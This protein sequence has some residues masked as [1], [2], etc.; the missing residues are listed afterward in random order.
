MSIIQ[1]PRRPRINLL[2]LLAAAFAVGTVWSGMRIVHEDRRQIIRMTVRDKAIEIATL[3]SERLHHLGRSDSATVRKAFEDLLA[4]DYVSDSTR[5]LHM[6]ARSISVSDRGVRV[7]GPPLDSTRILESAPLHGD[8]SHIVVTAMV[9]G[10]QLPSEMIFPFS[11]ERLITNG[12]FILGTMLTL[13]AAIVV[14]RRELRLA[15]ARS[16]FV[17]GVSHDLRMPLAQ[18]LLASETLAM[19]R[20]R[21][22]ADRERLTASILRETR[23][24]LGL[25]E[26]VLLFSRTGSVKLTPNLGLVSVDTLFA[27]VVEATHLAAEDAGQKIVT[28]SYTE[29]GVGPSVWGDRAL[30]RQALV[31][32]MDNSLKYGPRGQTVRLTASPGPRIVIAVEDEGPGIPAE[33]R[34]AMFLPYSRLDRDQSSERTGSGLGLA[35]V[36]QIVTACGGAVSIEDG[37]GKGTRVLVILS[38]AKERVSPSLRSGRQP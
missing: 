27:E 38:E 20:E 4:T 7:Y 35:V 25:V 26:N 19:G 13:A 33:K 10:H 12:L 14:S 3:A 36:R 15:E 30:L 31:N 21:D 32:L 2:W 23:R 37:A 16:S 17:A 5:V 6:D 9:S 28:V 22:A 29:N 8:L 34:E 1:V 24:L 18:I 11:H